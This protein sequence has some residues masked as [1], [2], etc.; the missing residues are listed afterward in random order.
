MLLDA[1]V[2]HAT[3]LATTPVESATGD[4][5]HW[6]QALLRQVTDL[7]DDLLDEEQID[8]TLAA[9]GRSRSDAAEFVQSFVHQRTLEGDKASFV[10]EFKA[11][12]ALRSPVP[13]RRPWAAR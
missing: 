6:K 8:L 9:L 7:R 5:K 10:D 1:C 13:R 2:A 11:R 3:A 4:A 12:M